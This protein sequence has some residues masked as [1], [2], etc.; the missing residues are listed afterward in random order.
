MNQTKFEAL[1]K[2]GETNNQIS[3]IDQTTI[4]QNF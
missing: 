1:S 2:I 4:Y 3:N